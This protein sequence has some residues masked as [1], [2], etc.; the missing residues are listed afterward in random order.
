LLTAVEMTEP[1]H[2]NGQ[3]V[4]VALPKPG[5]DNFTVNSRAGAVL[6]GPDPQS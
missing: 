4:A 6:T 5:G 1:Q 3:V 2:T